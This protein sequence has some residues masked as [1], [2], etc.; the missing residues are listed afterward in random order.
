MINMPRGLFKMLLSLSP[1]ATYIA[2]TC[3]RIK[4]LFTKPTA[5]W[6]QVS[7]IKLLDFVRRATEFQPLKSN[8]TR[9][10]VGAKY[11]IE[12]TRSHCLKRATNLIITEA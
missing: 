6:H 1:E 8:L 7:S 9:A 10:D 12:R 5:N 3:S 4:H 2:S 11:E